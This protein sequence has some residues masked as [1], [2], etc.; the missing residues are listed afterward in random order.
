M[1]LLFYLHS[2]L[3]KL[4][5]F[6][7]TAINF[8]HGL[9]HG[10]L[11]HIVNAL[12]LLHFKNSS[13]SEFVWILALSIT[14]Q[15]FSLLVSNLE[16][17]LISSCRKLMNTHLLNVFIRSHYSVYF[18]IGENYSETHWKALDHNPNKSFI[19]LYSPNFWS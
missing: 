4:T 13:T 7:I 9:S 15:T 10:E 17:E 5:F 1:L 14:N 19:F 2:S 16:N 3:S 18:A 8:S 12:I 6:L 11:G